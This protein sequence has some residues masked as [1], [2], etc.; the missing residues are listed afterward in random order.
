MNTVLSALK[1][2]QVGCCF[3]HQ[4][5]LK[6]AGAIVLRYGA[7]GRFSSVV[8]ANEGY[9]V[10]ALHGLKKNKMK[11]AKLKRKVPAAKR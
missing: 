8:E 2:K 10:I 9:L 6:E 4:L 11:V 3:C 1:N 7:Q 5:I